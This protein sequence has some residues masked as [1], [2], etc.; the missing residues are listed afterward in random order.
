MA[1]N[2]TSMS[3]LHVLHMLKVLGLTV[4]VL[5]C[6][7]FVSAQQI[8]INELRDVDFGRAAP[9]GGRLQADMRFCVV[10]DQRTTYRVLGYAEEVGG[11]FNL[12]SGP[13]RLPYTVRF[14][15]RRQARGFQEL[16]PGQYLSGLRTRGNNN[17]LC[18]RP[19]ARVRVELPASEL[20]R[21]P[22]GS[23]RSILTLM[24][25]PE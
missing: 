7:S 5:L 18:R 4:A 10:L 6:G 9:T 11:T 22:S 20:V 3:R 14:A 1:G 24:V 21:A 23:Y 16:I 8:V 12:A 13:Y 25:S 15:D 19:N 17:G 2:I